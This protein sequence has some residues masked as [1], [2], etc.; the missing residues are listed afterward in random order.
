MK[1][2]L[3]ARVQ[4]LSDYVPLSGARGQSWGLEA[5]CGRLT[6]LSGARGTAVLSAAFGLVLEAQRRDEP[7]AW[8][9]LRRGTFFPP[10]AARGGVDLESL[11]VVRVEQPAQAARAAD[12]LVRSGGFGL[13]V[14]DLAGQ[15]ADARLPAPLQSRLAGLAQKHDTAVLV[16]TDKPAEAPSLGALVG[17]RA[18]ARRET[19]FACV[20]RALKDKRRGPGHS[21]VE[22]CLPPEGYVP[23]GIE[24]MTTP[25][26][27]GPPRIALIRAVQP[28][29]AT[30]Q[31]G[32]G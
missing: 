32:A 23:T 11:V 31:P 30:H 13:V 12:Q 8:V 20:V 19:G 10:D 14:L 24:R 3:D 18:E 7:V 26:V 6:E 27:A 5:L 17:L 28:D 1:A 16:L 22:S 29:E 2:Q 4:R 21:H 15:P 9:A 25:A